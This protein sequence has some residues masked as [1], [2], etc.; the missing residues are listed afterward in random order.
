M[1]ASWEPVRE[2]PEIVRLTN[3]DC[4]QEYRE[5]KL[6]GNLD[7][8]FVDV[9]VYDE[10]GINVA[11]GAGVLGDWEDARARCEAFLNSLLKGTPGHEKESIYLG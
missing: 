2:R 5:P 11:S 6:L 4:S 3:Q 8:A 10:K 9:R 1:R 7:H